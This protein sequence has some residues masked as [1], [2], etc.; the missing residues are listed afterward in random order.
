MLTMQECCEAVVA[1]CPNSFARAYAAAYLD[2]TVAARVAKY[3][4]LGL[5]L[6]MATAVPAQASQI[7]CNTQRWRGP[8]ALETRA[9]LKAIIKSAM[10]SERI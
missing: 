1:S 5:N 2:G 3:Q 8:Q 6:T 7:L 4:A 10:R 9:A